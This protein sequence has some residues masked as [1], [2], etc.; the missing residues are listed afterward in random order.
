MDNLIIEELEDA[1]H[2]DGTEW[3]ET[4]CDLL[5]LYRSSMVSDS[6]KSSIEQEIL[7][8]YDAFKEYATIYETTET[9]TR[10][11]RNIEWN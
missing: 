2:L 10:V 7:D 9:Y 5:R 1:S 6:F 11:V 8:Q 3:G 4:I